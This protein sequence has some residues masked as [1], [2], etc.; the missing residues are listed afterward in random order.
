MCLWVSLVR[1]CISNFGINIFGSISSEK[2][3]DIFKVW[4]VYLHPLGRTDVYL[5]APDPVF[6]APWKVLCTLKTWLPGF[7]LATDA[8]EDDFTVTCGRWR[9]LQA[10]SQSKISP[11][12]TNL[13]STHQKGPL[14]GAVGGG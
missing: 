9:C 14:F 10:G 6:G 8:G 13:V 5:S 3:C 1:S 11:K 2:V 12:F 7:F 4:A